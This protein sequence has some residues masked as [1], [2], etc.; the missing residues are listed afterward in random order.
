MG[1][2]SLFLGVPTMNS[3]MAKNAAK[4]AMNKAQNM[5]N[6]AVGNTGPGGYPKGK[7]KDNWTDFLSDGNKC[8]MATICPCVSSAQTAERV[9]SCG[10]FNGT[11][12]IYIGLLVL[13]IAGIVISSI[14]SSSVVNTLALLVVWA[15]H[16]WVIKVL[17]TRMQ[18]LYEIPVDDPGMDCL[19]VCCCPCLVLAQLARH[20]ESDHKGACSKPDVIDG[21]SNGPAPAMAGTGPSSSVDSQ[22]RGV[23]SV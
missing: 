8:L 19:L 7:W 16:L 17:R 20:V 14:V 13:Y 15:L 4:G 1:T 12:G 22:G 5:M 2:L 11:V 9:Q 6:A 18:S 3:F 21:L 23:S 10:G